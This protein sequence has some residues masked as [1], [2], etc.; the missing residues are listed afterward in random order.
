MQTKHKL[1]DEQKKKNYI[2]LHIRAEKIKKM[3][4][5]TSKQ[6]NKETSANKH[7]KE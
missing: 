7:R 3:K 5:R 2:N 6:R 4:E 1:L